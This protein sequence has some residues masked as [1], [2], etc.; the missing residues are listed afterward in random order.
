[1]MIMRIADALEGI[2]DVPEAK[3]SVC[4]PSDKPV[5]EADFL[6]RLFDTLKDAVS[7]R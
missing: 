1:M 3:P 6:H 5:D 2:A 7:S 4:D